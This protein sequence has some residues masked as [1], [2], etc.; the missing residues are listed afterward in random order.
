MPKIMKGKTNRGVSRLLFLFC[1]VCD[2]EKGEKLFSFTLLGSAPWALEIK[3]T[4]DRVTR[5]KVL[6]NRSNAMFTEETQ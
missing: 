1:D 5:E 2:G 6:N 4:K 3:L